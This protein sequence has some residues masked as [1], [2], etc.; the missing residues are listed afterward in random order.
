MTKFLLFSSSTCGPCRMMKPAWERIVEK[1]KKDPETEFMSFIV[2]Q[3]NSAMPYV[4]RLKFDLF[5]PLSLVMRIMISSNPIL[6]FFLKNGWKNLFF[7]ILNMN[8]SYNVS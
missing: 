7:V 2:D 6:E 1:Y 8:Q 3:D 5:L 4:K